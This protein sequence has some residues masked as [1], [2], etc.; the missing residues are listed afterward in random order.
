MICQHPVPMYPVCTEE[1]AI[2]PLKLSD[3]RPQLNGKAFAGRGVGPG[4]EHR[5]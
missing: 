1:L 3:G 2:M 4:W 5:S